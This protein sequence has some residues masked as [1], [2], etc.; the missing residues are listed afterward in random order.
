M[1]TAKNAGR[2][3]RVNEDLLPLVYLGSLVNAEGAT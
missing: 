3:S 2:F 1:I